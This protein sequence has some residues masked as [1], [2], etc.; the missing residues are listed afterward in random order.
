MEKRIGAFL[1]LL[2]I[3]VVLPDTSHAMTVSADLDGTEKSGAQTY[4]DASG[5]YFYVDITGTYVNGCVN[6]TIA[7]Y[8]TGAGVPPPRVE[9]IDA[10]D[11]SDQL[12]LRNA[13][14]T[15]NSDSSCPDSAHIYFWATLTEPPTT[16]AGQKVT[17]AKS[18]VGV[19]SPAT[20]NN[21]IT[22]NAYAQNPVNP[23]PPD[24]VSGSWP[25]ICA[26]G[27]GCQDSYVVT[28]GTCGNF[29]KSKQRTYDPGVGQSFVGNRVY[30]GE[31][32]FKLVNKGNNLI[33]DNATKGI[34]IRTTTGSGGA[35]DC[36]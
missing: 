35:C 16:H 23:T 33:F 8:T 25:E 2:T 12:W 27:T 14:I 4:T 20:I 9:A 18:A 1:M 28:C 24:G 31:A 6:Y 22:V 32:W 15:N 29:S 36:Q 34:K 11:G 19:F 13:K 30:K 10:T 17:V 5:T 26:S 21:W 7:P 3:L